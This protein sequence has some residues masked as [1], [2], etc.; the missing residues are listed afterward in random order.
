MS[1]QEKSYFP[2][3]EAV[4]IPAPKERSGHPA[5][6]K[7]ALTKP[8][9]VQSLPTLAIL[10]FHLSVKTLSQHW[11]SLLATSK[12]HIV[13]WRKVIECWSHSDHLA[14]HLDTRCPDNEFWCSQGHDHWSACRSQKLD[15]PPH[16]MEKPEAWKS[17]GQSKPLSITKRARSQ[18]AQHLGF[19]L[20]PPAGLPCLQHVL[21]PWDPG[22][23]QGAIVKPAV[24]ACG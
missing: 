24:A 12:N 14:S 15:P 7:R 10:W 22:A 8:C 16:K 9:P 5:H 23:V 1:S 17:S 13:E 2:A 18:G 21:L 19:T 3:G 20:T 6:P 11:L 4:L